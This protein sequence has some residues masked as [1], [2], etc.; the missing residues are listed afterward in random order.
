MAKVVESVVA[1]QLPRLLEEANYLDL[2]QSG[3]RP[4]Y[5]TETALVALMDDLWRAR[6]GLF[7]CPG[8][9]RSLSGFRY[10]RP[11]YPVAAPR[12]VGGVRHHSSVVLLLPLGM[13]AISVGRRAEVGST[14]PRGVPQGSVLSPLLFNIY[15]KPLGEIIRGFG[16][17]YH[18]YADDTQLY[19]STPNQLSDA[20]PVMS[21]YLEAVRIWMGRNR[22]QLNPAKTEWLCVPASWLIQSAPSLVLGGEVLPPVDRARNLGVLLD[23][24]LSLEEQVGAVARGAFAQVCLVRQLRP[25]LDRDALRTV[26]HAFV[27]S[28]I[29]YC[30]ALYMGL[31]LRTMRRLQLVQN[32]AARAVMGMSRYSHITPLLRE[33]HWLP[34][35][36]RVRFKVLVLTYK[37]LHGLGPRYLREH[38]LP[39]SNTNRPV[40]T[41]RQGLLGV[42]SARQCRL[43]VPRGR[44]FMEPASPGATTGP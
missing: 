35:A 13:L 37:A 33:L 8:P 40:R 2:C 11:W 25:Y 41:H 29:D 18:Q 43:A 9:I 23:V 39:A 21:R 4:G 12:G 15:M 1:S 24:R 38:L 22:L 14:A 44:A 6:D 26:T 36:L 5:S 42:L 16:V 7:L 30:N 28:W 27:T 17:R 3:F 32:A 20:F 19:I 31:P 10:H 34:V